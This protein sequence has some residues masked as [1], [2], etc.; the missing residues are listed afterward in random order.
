MTLAG[1]SKQTVEIFNRGSYVAP[2][3][4]EVA[5]RELVDAAVGGTVLHCPGDYEGL[6]F[7]TRTGAPL[8]KLEITG[9]ST[10]EASRRLVQLEGLTG[11][12]ALNFASAKNPGGGFLGG[13]KAQ[14]EDLARCSALYAC[15]LR[16]PAYYEA[17]RSTHSMLY[18]DHIIYAPSVPVFRDHS[19]ELL[20][21][22][23]S[24]SVITAPAPNAGRSVNSGEKRGRRGQSGA[25]SESG[26]CAH[27][28]CISRQSHHRAGSLG[29]RRVSQ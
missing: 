16:Q 2:S 6:R 25:G 3:G 11:V 14:E 9:E 1:I 28:G 22:P 8:P 13:A 17:N 5:L 12:A 27:G 26:P 19:L 29:L 18:T 24:V 23:F 21:S 4:R 15:Q 10:L 20:E 7:E